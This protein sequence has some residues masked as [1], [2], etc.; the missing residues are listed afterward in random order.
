MKKGRLFFRLLWGYLRLYL[1]RIAFL[2]L[3]CAVFCSLHLLGLGEMREL[4]YALAINGLFFCVTFIITF[5]RYAKRQIL[6]WQ[7]LAEPPPEPASLPA[8]HGPLEEAFRGL[9]EAYARENRSHADRAV[10]LEVERND[11]YTLWV[12]QVKTPIAALNLIAQSEKPI[13]REQLK[14]EIYKIEQYA[15]AVLS[16]Q[17]LSSFSSDLELS[18][19]ALYPLCCKVVKK[20]RPL[21]VYRKIRLNMEAFS[22]AALTDAK[23]LGIAM[24]QVLTNALK[25]TPE[26]GEITVALAAPQVLTIADTGIGIRTEDIPRV[27]D[28]GF[29]GET[30]RNGNKSTGIGLYLCKQACGKLGHGLSLASQVGRGTVVTFDLRREDFEAF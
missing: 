11:Y 5:S 7:A 17:R 26:G 23:W 25:Y 13:D 16:F 29:T 28:R 21:F 12:H 14:Q 9:A 4:G 24:E 27:F 8:A 6:L 20:L 18:E 2:L 10:A 1:P 22:G 15:E 30:G 3:I 19:V